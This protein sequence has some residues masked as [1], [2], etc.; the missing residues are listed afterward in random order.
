MFNLANISLY[1]ILLPSGMVLFTFKIKQFDRQIF[2]VR[3]LVLFALSLNVFN[4]CYLSIPEEM[5]ENKNNM[6]LFHIYTLIEGIVLIVYYMLFFLSRRM[7]ILIQLLLV[8]FVVVCILDIM[9]FESIKTY[10]SIP[11]T[12]ECIFIT[13]LSISFFIN[14]FHK[15]EIIELAKYP[16]FWMVSGYLLFFAGTFFMNIVGKLVNQVDA[17]GYNLYDIYSYLNI[18]L[19]IIYA[20]TLWLGS[21]KLTSVQ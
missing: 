17:V 7:K 12:V 20:I 5:L 18:F 16:H 4:V 10:P 19:N 3:F 1:S 11:R 9:F 2:I 14:L 13:I 6:F 21:R 15:S 8:S